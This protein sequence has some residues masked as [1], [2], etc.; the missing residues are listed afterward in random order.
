MTSNPNGKRDINQIIT[1]MVLN[2][3]ISPRLF[4]TVIN[5][6]R[7]SKTLRQQMKEYSK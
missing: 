4:K 2:P 7:K 3:D 1:D 5:I 6:F